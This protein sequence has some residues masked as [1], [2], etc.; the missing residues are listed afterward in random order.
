MY[1]E[2]KIDNKRRSSLRIFSAFI[3]K[4]AIVNSVLD[5]STSLVRIRSNPYFR[6]HLQIPPSITERFLGSDLNSSCCSAVCTSVSTCFLRG[7][8]L[9]Q[10]LLAPQNFLFSIFI[11]IE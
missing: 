1:T 5:V 10:I 3:T 2:T 7:R 9:S 11:K 4:N 6:L 8:P